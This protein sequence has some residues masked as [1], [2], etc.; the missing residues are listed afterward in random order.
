M[1]PPALLKKREHEWSKSHLDHVND[2]SM[3]L[4]LIGVNLESLPV[5]G[6]IDCLRVWISRCVPLMNIG[7]MLN[8]ALQ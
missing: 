6:W 7:R 2:P 3:S 8:A 4:I 1:I 5:Q